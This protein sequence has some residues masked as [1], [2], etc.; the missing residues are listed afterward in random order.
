MKSV[1]SLFV[2][3][4][5][6]CE[7]YVPPGCITLAISFHNVVVGWRL[8]MTSKLSSENGKSA[9]SGIWTIEVPYRSR[10][11]RAIG[12]FGLHDSD[13]TMRPG[14][15]SMCE[16]TS[17]N[18]SPPP[19]CKSKTAFERAIRSRNAWEYP[20]EG[21]ASVALPSS[22]ENS[23]PSVGSEFASSRSCSNLSV[24]DMRQLCRSPSEC[25]T[26]GK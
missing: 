24:V 8:Q 1:S 25:E 13:A 4:P 15:G 6:C 21:R 12:T 10:L 14:T 2:P 19:V 22:H 11:C 7:R 5:T 9:S 23:Q 16:R 3:T 18:R 17:A 26:I 20:H